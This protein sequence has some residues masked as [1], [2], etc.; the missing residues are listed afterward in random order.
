MKI[1]AIFATC[2]VLAS[3]DA[4]TTGQLGSVTNYV[5]HLPAATITN[6]ITTNWVT[7]G[8]LSPPPPTERF[9]TFLGYQPTLEIQSGTIVSNTIAVIVWRGITN[10]CV[11]KSEP[12]QAGLER[13]LDY[14]WKTVIWQKMPH[15]ARGTWQAGETVRNPSVHDAYPANETRKDPKP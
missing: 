7:T 5:S 11:M 2:L 12:V 10:S 6:S 1:L 14:N 13:H 9:S 4:I 3:E 15:S 8:I